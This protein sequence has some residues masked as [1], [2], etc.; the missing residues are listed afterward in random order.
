MIFRTISLMIDCLYWPLFICLVLSP[1]FIKTSK[2]RILIVLFGVIVLAWRFSIVLLSSRYCSFL[3]LCALLSLS[4]LIKEKNPSS[5]NV[6]LFLFSIALAVQLIK[7]FSGFNNLYVLDLSDDISHLSLD[8]QRILLVQEK[9]IERVSSMCPNDCFIDTIENKPVVLGANNVFEITRDI[10]PR[11]KVLGVKKTGKHADNK[12]YI[13]EKGNELLPNEVSVQE[14]KN[15]IFNGGLETIQ[16]AG[17]NALVNRL[18]D[19]GA[20]FYS[21]DN[22]KIPFNSILLPL[23][24]YNG[25]PEV[26]ADSSNPISGDYSLNVRFF[27]EGM[28]YFLNRFR[29]SDGV[30][31]F[32]IK[33]ISGSSSLFLERVDYDESFLNYRYGLPQNIYIFDNNV[34]YVSLPFLKSDFFGSNTLF[35]LKGRQ[36]NFLLDNICYH[37]KEL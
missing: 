18:I 27:D 9:E 22:V 35:Y 31:S 34:H 6:F 5:R 24:Y 23:N 12:L 33:K 25:F 30:L 36:I 3:I 26:F 10:S 37:P 2:K 8:K 28:V 20:S 29:P 7:C 19:S 11:S 1:F 17:Q 14:N 13:A 16:E 15:L 32:Y 21:S 4:L